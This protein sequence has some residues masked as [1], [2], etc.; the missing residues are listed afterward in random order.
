LAQDIYEEAIK[1]SSKVYSEL[2]V[3]MSAEVDVQDLNNLRLGIYLE[4]LKRK[5]S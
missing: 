2:S 3:K 5:R 4:L 1:L